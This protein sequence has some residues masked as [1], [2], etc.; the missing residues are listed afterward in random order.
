VPK[1]LCNFLGAPKT[2]KNG[3]R[4]KIYWGWNGIVGCRTN[5]LDMALNGTTTMA[6]LIH[7]DTVDKLINQWF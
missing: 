2:S 4:M 5:S 6:V 3:D 1:A 7:R